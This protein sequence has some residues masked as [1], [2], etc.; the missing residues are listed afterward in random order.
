MKCKLKFCLLKVGKKPREGQYGG[1]HFSMYEQTELKTTS[2]S[3]GDKTLHHKEQN[4]T[5]EVNFQTDSTQQQQQE[6]NQTHTDKNNSNSISNSVNVNP[7]KT[8]KFL[9]LAR[10][11]KRLWRADA[12]SGNVLQT[13]NFQ[14]SF[15]KIKPF[16]LF[17]SLLS[18]T[19]KSFLSISHL[20][21][22]LLSLFAFLP[23]FVELFVFLFSSTS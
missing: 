2:T 1:I 7:G 21:F 6:S 14:T 5:N 20:F 16:P 22:P 12:V 15:S 18:G 3:H 13:L 23:H 11:G 10:P 8:K 19:P 4:H 9:I 17:T